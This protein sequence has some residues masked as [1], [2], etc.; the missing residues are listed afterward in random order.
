MSAQVEIIGINSGARYN[1]L[2]ASAYNSLASALRALS[3][4]RNVK[5]NAYGEAY[6]PSSTQAW[7]PQTVAAFVLASPDNV[8][9]DW[10]GYPGYYQVSASG[11]A[12]APQSAGW[13]AL[14]TAL[15]YRWLSESDFAVPANLE[16]VLIGG[17]KFGGFP[18]KRGW[19]L[20]PS[21]N[22]VLYSGTGTV[23]LSGRL[24]VVFEVP[25][26]Q[27]TNVAAT[28]NGYAMV[29]DVHHGKMGHYIYAAAD[30]SKVSQ[31]QHWVD[32]QSVAAW[33]EKF[34]AA[35]A[36]TSG[37]ST[38]SSR[39][40]GVASGVSYNVNTPPPQSASGGSSPYQA[41]PSKQTTSKV[42]AAAPVD[43]QTVGL[44]AAGTAAAG[45]LVYA[46]ASMLGEGK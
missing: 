15:G 19:S 3:G 14:A 46:I 20:A 24:D 6:G 13:A 2:P 38:V 7:S 8:W 17:Q 43:W 22:G 23:T 44:V 40:P 9:I 5:I 1:P 4:Q 42:K 36:A 37:V 29:A 45:G 33:V 21:Q 31:A 11:V 41:L 18:L 27:E 39:Q 30:P 12:T 26:Y 10:C 34:L 35:A 25:L 28:Q 16:A 32:A